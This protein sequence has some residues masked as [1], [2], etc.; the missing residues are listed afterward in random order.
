MGKEIH[1]GTISIHY[2]DICMIKD[3]CKF[4]IELLLRKEH[5]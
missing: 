2:D 3:H 1:T 4:S 5:E